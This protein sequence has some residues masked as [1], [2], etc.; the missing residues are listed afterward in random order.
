MMRSLAVVSLLAACGGHGSSSD[1]DDGTYNCATETRADT[2]VVGLEKHGTAGTLDFKLMSATPAPPARGDNTWILQ[3]NQMAAGVVGTP[4]TGAG[5]TV[6]PF[7]PDHQHGTPV[8]V[9]VVEMPTA[10]QYQ[11]MPVNLWMPGLWQTTITVNQG[12][13]DKVVYSFCIPS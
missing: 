3:I 13:S 1:A 4:V 11:L 10:G 5:M 12:G 9:H 8:T 6:E 2:F 7:M